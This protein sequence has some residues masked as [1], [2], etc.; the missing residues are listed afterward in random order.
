M[1][2]W[3]FLREYKKLKIEPIYKS[4]IYVLSSSVD[5]DNVLKSL[6]NPW[7]EAYLAKPIDTN[8]LKSIFEAN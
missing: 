3:Q 7:V 1:D 8:T 6:S 4:K 2:G 5:Y